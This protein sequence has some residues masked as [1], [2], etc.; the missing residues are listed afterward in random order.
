MSFISIPI[1]HKI[2]PFHA[3]LAPITGQGAAARPQPE[4]ALLADEV[5]PSD[6]RAFLEQV[7]VQAQATDQIGGLF[8]SGV[9][10]MNVIQQ[11]QRDPVFVSPE[12]G[13]ATQFGMAAE[14]GTL[15]FLA[16]NYSSGT[17]FFDLDIGHVI[18]VAYGDGSSRHFRITQLRHFQALAPAD[19]N[20]DFIDLDHDGQ[21][22][23]NNDLFYNIYAQQGRLVL[24][25]CIEA[26]GDW[27]WGRLF[28]VA[29]PIEPMPH[30]LWQVQHKLQK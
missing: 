26:G 7:Q 20:S 3:L 4:V 18:S 25:T 19:P 24:Q 30:L 29:E 15:G 27:A 2:Q 17:Q 21:R 14:F 5:G 9:L 12:P 10:A 16:H 8:V 11:P 1:F 28:V 23:S 13:V 6:W 22:V